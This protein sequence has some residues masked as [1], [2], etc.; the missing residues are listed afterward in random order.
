MSHLKD[1]KTIKISKE[2]Y[3]ALEKELK[4]RKPS[5]PYWNITS[6]ASYLIMEGLKRAKQKNE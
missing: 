2:I 4:R 1:T 3:E 6:L 5:E